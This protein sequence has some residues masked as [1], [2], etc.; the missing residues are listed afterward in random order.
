MSFLFHIVLKW[1][2]IEI[3]IVKSAKKKIS[4]KS[5]PNVNTTFFEARLVTVI[6]IKQK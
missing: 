2:S 4:R 1:C 5:D 6:G 3:C